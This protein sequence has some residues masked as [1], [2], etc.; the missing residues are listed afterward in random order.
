MHELQFLEILGL[1]IIHICL[2][3]LHHHT[4]QSIAYLASSVSVSLSL[5]TLVLTKKDRSTFASSSFMTIMCL[6]NPHA[7]APILSRPFPVYYLQSIKKLNKRNYS[8]ISFTLLNQ[9]HNFLLVPFI[10]VFVNQVFFFLLY[11]QIENNLSHF[12]NS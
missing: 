5:S 3:P 12:L 11:Y 4:H 2:F 6:S 8:L 9:P 1:S 7:S 10:Y